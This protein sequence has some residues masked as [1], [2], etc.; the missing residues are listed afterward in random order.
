MGVRVNTG[1]GID[2]QLVNKLVELERQPIKKIETR[3]KDLEEERKLF[4]EFT[5]LVS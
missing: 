4:R 1:S 5:Q 3:K 2:P